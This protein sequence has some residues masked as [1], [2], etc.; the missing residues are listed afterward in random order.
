MDNQLRP[1]NISLRRAPPKYLQFCFIV[2]R[3]TDIS[4]VRD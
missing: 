4:C 3:K 2:S 1:A